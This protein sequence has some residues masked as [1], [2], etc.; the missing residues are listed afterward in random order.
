MARHLLEL[1]LRQRAKH[2]SWRVGL[3]VTASQVTWIVKHNGCFSPRWQT[4]PACLNHS[5]QKLT[6]MLN[7]KLGTQ[8]RVLVFERIETVGT[9]RQ[10][11]HHGM[12]LERRNIVPCELLE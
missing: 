2:L 4:Q 9:M 6:V 11:L 1:D 8:R 5:G 10:H 7:G 3:A 12:T